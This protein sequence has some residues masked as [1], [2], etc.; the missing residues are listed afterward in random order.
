MTRPTF[1]LSITHDNII[2]A[3]QFDGK[4]TKPV[5]IS[6]NHFNEVKDLVRDG[7]LPEKIGQ[8]L[9]NKISTLLDIKAALKDRD[10]LRLRL[11]IE[12]ADLAALPWEML[13]DGK[14]WL[15]VDGH[16]SIVRTT[17]K[18]T[19]VDS[20][21]VNKLNILLVGASPKNLPDLEIQ[22]IEEI[23]RLLNEAVEKKQLKRQQIE[24]KQLLD[25]TWEQVSHELARNYYHVLYFIGHGTPTEIYFD[26]GEGVAIK[27]G[28]KPGDSY[29]ITVPM[30]ADALKK[31]S[32]L[33]LLFLAACD[34]AKYEQG[35]SFA[36]NLLAQTSLPVLVAMQAE[37]D[38]DRANLLAARFFIALASFDE[39]DVALTEART[40]L[41]TSDDISPDAFAPVMYLQAHDG[42]LFKAA[43]NRVAWWL[44][45]L[46][47][48]VV[49]LAGAATYY[50]QGETTTH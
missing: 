6:P 24:C 31:N 38:D 1:T 29:A 20:L 26:D 27:D 49:L 11:D 44:T 23:D 10:N 12:P 30:L 36:T 47:A 19:Q 3:T 21:A 34:T 22:R 48:I 15:A 28:H 39:V 42:R 9:Y 2:Q 13:Y 37:V 35:S 18:Q 17:A 32:N 50:Q 8:A 14:N 16:R 41:Q 4:M 43:W 46:L 33:R 7:A 45:T 5:S 40:A 25:A